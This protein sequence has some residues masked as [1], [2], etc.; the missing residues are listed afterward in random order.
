V[1]VRRVRAGKEQEY[2]SHLKV[3]HQLVQGVPG[4]L[5]TDIVRDA[6]AHEYVSI[7]RFDSLENLRAWQASGQHEH[8]QLD[9]DGIVEGDAQVRR[10]EGLEFWFN[11]P[12]AA[13]KPPSRH[14]MAV[15]LVVLVTVMSLCFT[16][17]ILHYFGTAPRLI[18]AFISATLQVILLT[19][20]IMPRVTRVLAF[21]LFEEPPHAATQHE[22]T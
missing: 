14:K 17:V 18:R 13:T 22:G 4:Y 1:F 5:G 10:C 20:V 12:N 16:P 21:W 9:L 2:E 15:V 11:V 6:A 19:Y 8:W 3:L 7:V